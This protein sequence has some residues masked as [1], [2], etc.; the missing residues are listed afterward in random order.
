MIIPRV[1]LCLATSCLLGIGSLS[2]QTTLIPSGAT[3]SWLPGTTEASNPIA[4]WRQPAFV[5]SGWSSGAMPFWY[6]DILAGG[7]QITGMQNVHTS[8]F[9][10]KT[11]TITNPTEI[12]G[13]IINAK[14]DDGF[15]AWING[16]EVARYNVTTQDPIFSSTAAISVA[17]PPPYAN[18]PLPDPRTFL[19]SGTNVLAIMGFN[20]TSGSSDF[21]LD[22]TLAT[23]GPDGT[24]PT[25]TAINPPPGNLAT[26]TSIT[27]TFSEPVRGITPDDLVIN[28]TAAESV[29]GAGDTWTFTF[30]QPPYGDV[31]V[32]WSPAHNLSDINTPAHAFDETAPG[33]TWAYSL[34][35]SI[36]PFVTG[37]NPPANAT[38]ISLS[39]IEV[40]FNEPIVGLN[41]GD[42]IVNGSPATNVVGSAGNKYTFT[43]PAVAP[44][45]ISVSWAGGHGI[46][47]LAVPPNQFA[48]GS[49]TYTVDPNAVLTGVRINEFV[50]ANVNGILDENS[51][52]QDWIELHNPTGA[53]VSLDGWS[54]TDD[55]TYPDKWIFP[56]RTIPAGGYLLVFCS[57]K[58]R[59]S[60]TGNLHTNFK[61]ASPDGEYLALFN[62]QSPR[63]IASIFTPEYPEQRNDFSYGIDSQGVWRYYATPTPNA[64]NGTSAISEVA[65]NVNFSVGRGFFGAPFQLHLSS[66]TPGAVIRYT[67]DGSAPS[68]TSPLYV[69]SIAITN[70]TCVRAVAFAGNSLPSLAGTQTYIFPA[71]VKNQSAAPAGFPTVWGTGGNQIAADYEVD[72]TV[73]NDANYS[74]TFASDLM[75]IPSMSIVMKL[76]DIF[77]VTGINSNPGGSGIAWER[78]ASLELIYPDGR[79]GFQ[80]DCG[81][82]IQ[83]GFGRS[84]SIKKHSFRPLFKSDYGPSKLEFPLFEGSPVTEFD[85]F[86]LRAGMNNSYVLSTG[87][88][89]RATFT[90]DEW[91]RQTQRAMGQVSGYGNFVHL[92]INGLY[93]GLYNATERPSAPFAAGHFGGEKEDWDAL[94]SSEPVDG[95]KT[96]WTTLLNLCSNAGNV[97]F[98]V[99]QNEWNQVS[100]YLD[101]DNLIDY[102]LLNC[103]GGNQDW[104]DHNWYSARLRVAGAG[105]KFFSWDGERTLETPTGQDRTGVNQADKPSRIYA[106]LRGSTNI[107]TA[108]LNPAN[109][110]FRVRFADRIQK[111]MFANGPL[112]PAEA[113]KRWN[114]VQAQVDRA[115]VGESARWGDKLREPPYTRNAEFM[116]EVNR[117]RNTQFPQRTAAVLTQLR[118][119]G[120]FPPASL[121]A[122]ILN[123]H[124]G[125]V[126]A[127]FNLT[128]S[129]S[130]TGTIYY[131][132]DGTD[133]RTAWTSTSSGGS[134]VSWSGSVAP[135]ALTY[136]G[137]VSLGTSRT[138]KARVRE[139]ST[140]LWSA[141]T[142]APF[143]VAELSIP[144][145]ITEVM[146]N[147][148]GGDAYEFIELQNVGSDTVD[149]GLMSF[150][151]INFTFLRNTTLAAGARLVLASNV[152][153]SQWA[154]RYPGVTPAGYFG[155]ALSNSSELIRLLD[156]AGNVVT[157]F[158][159]AEGGPW[160][161]AAD[162]TG[163]SLELVDFNGDPSLGTS[164]RASVANNGTPG[165]P[166][167]PFSPAVRINEVLAWNAGGTS[168]GGVVADYVEIVNPG[169]SPVNISLWSVRPFGFLT[170]ACVFPPNTILAPGASITVLCGTQNGQFN[171]DLLLPNERGF[172]SLNMENGVLVDGLYWGQQIPDKA[173]GLVGSN[174]VLT[175]PTPGVI[176]NTAAPVANVTQ[177]AVNE[178]LAQSPPPSQAQWIELANRDASLPLALSGLQ[179]QVGNGV[180][181]FRIPA[182][183]PAG[184]YQVLPLPSSPPD[185]TIDLRLPIA[186]GA[187][188]IY[189]PDSA[190]LNSLAYTT[191]QREVSQG[192]LP[193]GT[194]P[195]T[196]FPLAATPGAANAL[197]NYSGPVLNEVLARNEGVVLDAA[198]NWPDFIEFFNPG[199]SSFDMSGMKLRRNFTTDPDWVFPAGSIV[200][201]GGYL[202]IWC[203]PS[204]AVDAT[205]IGKDL[206]DSGGDIELFTASGQKVNEIDYGPQARNLSIGIAAG[207][208]KLLSQPTPGAANSIAASL[209]LATNL[210]INEWMALADGGEDWLELYNTD[211]LPVD[212]SGLYLTDNASLAGRADTAIRPRSFIAGHGHS[213][214]DASGDINASPNATNFRLSAEGE[215]LRL[216]SA[217]LAALDS[218]DFGQATPDVSRGRYTDGTATLRAFPATVSRGFANYI[219]SDGDGVPDAWE[220]A[221]NTNPLLADA[222]ADP[223]GDGRNN[224][225]EFNAGT[226]PQNAASVF[227]AEVE[228]TVNGFTIR[229]TAQQDRTYT[230]QY[231]NSLLDANWQILRNIPAAEA[232]NVQVIDSTASGSSRFYRVVTPRE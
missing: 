16:V 121:V 95:V 165:G 177:V 162:G 231:K 20:N 167:Q 122:P 138:I 170:G 201:A 50:A 1:L 118:N 116:T 108:P 92:Y 131:T 195:L 132:T 181:R 179:L 83:G 159:Y 60:A 30:D 135:G 51:E 54:L 140:G 109:V 112:T 142:E 224:A 86:V 47:D 22:V 57:G 70:T 129:S 24:V 115:V 87:E 89:N 66:A 17:E 43:F 42:L 153:P 211:S 77:G 197:L 176:T 98:I 126:A 55:E 228:A 218:V 137:P 182:F 133:P 29:S 172:V 103:Y 223:D 69:G 38:V 220:L 32:A 13:L 40:T 147:P 80:Q 56:A 63:Q 173:V 157:S 117:K 210:R 143:Q 61:L 104:D 73:T 19:V 124:G 94:N 106:A 91:M 81:M 72:P 14:S 34:T 88:A 144:I 96:A 39:Q 18:F 127:G 64:A 151:G 215:A 31:L 99:D 214:F 154:T 49:W 146:Y 166:N 222:S 62:S 230:L 35:D 36:A 194:G 158:R 191:T 193:N 155:G 160:P 184:G 97:R 199:A 161:T 79:S 114:T 169:T 187:I 226:N 68:A 168:I 219:D 90:E 188:T 178:F 136:G 111:H 183:I 46:A 163:R 202:R 11:F 93:W 203:D 7:T 150:E 120:L 4:A 205:N 33:T 198:G 207:A 76:E 102:M 217:S 119:A 149:V 105:Y 53:A 78:P 204:R 25:I 100:A 10:R 12:G 213:V 152:S 3:W 123:Q 208:W 171:A 27:V 9:F 15:I 74:A 26:L 84:V 200:S 85:T 125:K 186:N 190:Q 196:S 225:A 189:G 145:R 164:W 52:T 128:M 180:H 216:Y 45:A 113:V 110:E 101:V 185:H 209:G 2:A 232:R 28:Q 41:A 130:T 227:G 48:G 175:Q 58:D 65:G 71:L 44:G 206:S 174:W 23:T 82:R 141:L 8:L 221:N 134:A 192:R 59:R 67:T 37:L 139:T 156:S 107:T 212:L 229:F 21:G 148:V 6:G 5:E 75:A